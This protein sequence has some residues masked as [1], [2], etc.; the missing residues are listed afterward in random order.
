MQRRSRPGGRDRG[1]QRHARGQSRPAYRIRGGIVRASLGDDDR[2][3]GGL[4][5]RCHL[6]ACRTIGAGEADVIVAGGAESAL[7]R[8]LAHRQAQSSISSRTSC[9]SSPDTEE[10]EEPETIEATEAVSKVLG[11]SRSQQ[12]AWAL[13][14]HLKAEAARSDRRF[15][16]E[17][18]PLRANA[19][20]ARDQS[21]IE[22]DMAD[23]ERL[24]PF[25]RPGGTLTPGNTSAMH[26]GSAIVVVVSDKVWQELGRPKRFELVG[27]APQ[28]VSPE[29][30]AV[31][32]IE[33]MKKLYSRLEGFNPKDIGIVELS[34]TSAAQALAFSTSLGLNEDMLNPDGGAIVRAGRSARRERCWWSGC[35]RAWCGRRT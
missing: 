5:P 30:D 16:G 22:P 34:E 8:A 3:P 24:T 33:A 21:A 13:R 18:V 15:A 31:A 4:R 35:S 7:N 17:I 6:A 29:N 19:E 32:P 11:I 9:G 14:S 2:P 10:D 1:R 20:E 12:D 26:D 23:L 27:S 28:G 25:M